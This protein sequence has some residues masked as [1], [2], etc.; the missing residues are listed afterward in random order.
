MTGLTA[1]FRAFGAKGINTR[2]S[3]SARTPD[4]RVVMTFWQDQFLPSQ[5]LSYSNI[6]RLDLADWQDQPGNQERIENLRLAHDRWS[7][8]M[9]VVIITAIDVDDHARSI[10]KAFPRKDL[11]MRLNELNRET[12][13]FSTDEAAPLAMIEAPLKLEELLTSQAAKNGTEIIRMQL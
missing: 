5:P 9:G 13:E 12:G 2:W 3:W 1:A 6:G 10:D 7:G 11:L 8:L 4:D